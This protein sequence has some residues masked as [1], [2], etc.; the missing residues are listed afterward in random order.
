MLPY[1]IL[2]KVIL[3]NQ[4][5][6]HLHNYC[7]IYHITLTNQL[8]KSYQKLTTLFIGRPGGPPFYI[9][10]QDNTENHGPGSQGSKSEVKRLIGFLLSI[11]FLLSSFFFLISSFFFLLLSSSFFLISSFFFLL[12]FSSFFLLSS[13]LFL[14]SCFFFVFCFTT[15]SMLIFRFV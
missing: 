9:S 15:T 12:L 13:F 3:P 8:I 4:Y 5:Y 6:D 7:N 10:T 11:V 1:A 2:N 14:I